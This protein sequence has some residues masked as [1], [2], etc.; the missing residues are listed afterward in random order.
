MEIAAALIAG[1]AIGFVLG[2]IGAGGAMLTVPILILGFGMNAHQATTAS[3]A[4]VGAA[5]LSGAIAK[6]RNKEILYKDAF[7][8]W[9]IGL[10][11]NIGFASIV[12]RIPNLI[13]TIGFASVMTAAA[14][15]MI[16]PSQEQDHRRMP[17]PSL[18]FLSL[19]IGSI[20]GLFGIG[21][22]FIA[23]PI[24]VRFFGTPQVIAAGTSLAIIALNS[25][26]SLL[27]RHA[28]WSEV[29]WK[30]PLTMAL[31]AVVVS[32]IATRYARIVKTEIARRA[33]GYFLMTMAIVSLIQAALN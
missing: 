29:E 2:F 10:L 7:I 30:V 25:L 12:H 11:T 31:T 32:I 18:I 8:I 3:L 33:F 24:L 19:L 4:V 28:L 22:G 21:G 13:I 27:S 17:L 9:A 26:T 16:V 6:A 1:I 14:F 5:A 15:S 23:I 20:T